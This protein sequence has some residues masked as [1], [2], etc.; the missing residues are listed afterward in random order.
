MFT[1]RARRTTV[2][3]AI[4]VSMLMNL[5]VTTNVFAEDVLDT[6]VK[7][8]AVEDTK[9]EETVAIDRKSVV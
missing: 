5:C 3:W 2:T 1:K 6:E 8:I 4:L 7:Q 9:E